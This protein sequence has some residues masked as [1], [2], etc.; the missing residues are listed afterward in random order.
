MNSILGTAL[1]AK[2]P[3]VAG[4]AGNQLNKTNGQLDIEEMTEHIKGL[5]SSNFD[6]KQTNEQKHQEP[7]SI[8]SKNK[9]FTKTNNKCATYPLIIKKPSGEIVPVPYRENSAFGIGIKNITS[10]N[11][12]T[13]VKRNLN[14]NHVSTLT[15][16]QQVGY[17]FLNFLN[18]KYSHNFTFIHNLLL[19][20]MIL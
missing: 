11:G 18:L 8:N 7:I 10:I 19:F 2:K 13:V 1:K 20:G 16:V 9:S 3:Q 4:K 12:T 14:P 5:I 15:N 6:Q 17:I